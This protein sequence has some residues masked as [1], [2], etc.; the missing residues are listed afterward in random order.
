MSSRREKVKDAVTIKF[1]CKCGLSLKAADNLAG[2]RAKCTG[3]GEIVVIPQ[4][5]QSPEPVNPPAAGDN[6]PH[7]PIC[8]SA[9]SSSDNLTICPE[10]QTR[11]HTDCWN[12]IGGCAVYGCS[13]TPTTEHRTDLEIPPAYWGQENKPCPACCSVI[14]ASAIRC[15]HCGATFQSSRPQDQN[16]YTSQ[17]DTK[18][19][20][21]ELR[22]AV[23]WL[24]IFCV[25]PFSA[26]F[27]A[28]VGTFWYS[29][30]I[31]HLKAL[32]ALY[33]AITKLAILAAI[34]QTVFIIIIV[35][36]AANYH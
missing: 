18:K 31:H 21:P 2:K 17:M 27:A 23:I 3:C 35:I 26:P 14:L 24:F 4:P 16:E 30:N 12:E 8:Q 36:L 6:T 9:I 32:P 7:C 1:K 20:L 5:D 28:V 25:I 11:Y 33:S 29:S 10:C 19:R 15:R 13:K 22:R 34:G